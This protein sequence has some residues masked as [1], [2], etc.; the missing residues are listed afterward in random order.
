VP[1]RPSLILLDAGASGIQA[2]SITEKWEKHQTR[3]SA[4]NIA[5]L[6]K[7]LFILGRQTGTVWID[8]FTVTK[9]AK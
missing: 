1:P 4:K 3:F 2:F 7:I 6:N 8:D 5:A 9:E